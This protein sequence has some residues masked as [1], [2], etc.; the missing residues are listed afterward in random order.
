MMARLFTQAMAFRLSQ[1]NLLLPALHGLARIYFK[2]RGYRWETRRNGEV[3]LG[4]WRKTFRKRP[5]N[6]AYPKRLVLVPGLGDT[7]LSWYGVLALLTP[8]L[9]KQFDEV[10]LMDFPGFGGFLSREKTFPSFD[11][12]MATYN[13]TM[14]W[15][16]PHTIIGHSL[17]AWVT[18]SYASLCGGE[19][20]P[21]TNRLNYSGPEK[22][23]LVNP[24]GIFLNEQM[25]SDWIARFRRAMVEGFSVL[26]PHLFVKE[27]RWFPWIVPF[28]ADFFSR[29]DVIQFMDSFREEHALVHV[30]HQIQCPVWIVWGEGDSLIPSECATAWLEVLRS[31]SPE[32]HHALLIKAV[33]HSPHLERPGVTAAVLARILGSN[34]STQFEGRWWK[35][36]TEKVLLA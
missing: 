10:I 22:I 29:E 7:P 27:P 28:F 6:S 20:R 19:Q 30:V 32:K 36:V 34:Q 9:R 35:R 21:V 18:A 24:S 31:E 8:L 3:Q 23:I 33:G 14:D 13:D 1:K 12:M 26:R 25:K 2:N 17:G 16:K 11:L 5:H 4:L 15:L